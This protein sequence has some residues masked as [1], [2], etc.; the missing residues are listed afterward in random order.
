MGLL[1]QEEILGSPNLSRSEADHGIRCRRWGPVESQ[2]Q[3]FREENDMVVNEMRKQIETPANQ[4]RINIGSEIDTDVECE[5]VGM[6]PEGGLKQGSLKSREG[7]GRP[8]S[9]VTGRTCM[10]Y[11]PGNGDGMRRVLMRNNIV[12]A[13]G[14]EIFRDGRVQNRNC[15]GIRKSEPLSC[16]RLVGPILVGKPTDLDGQYRDFGIDTAEYLE[17]QDAK[18]STEKDEAIDCLMTTQSEQEQ[19]NQRYRRYGEFDSDTGTQKR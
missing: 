1:F 12:R 15:R 16:R 18:F 10:L 4:S 19:R 17:V 2:L 6:N 8:L 7:I 9:K 5:P 13:T 14:R 11:K 3:R